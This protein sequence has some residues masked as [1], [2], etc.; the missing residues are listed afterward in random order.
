MHGWSGIDYCLLSFC[1][2]VF[3]SHCMCVFAYFRL[4]VFSYFL[5]SYLRLPRGAQLVWNWLL[6]PAGTF[7]ATPA[8]RAAPHPWQCPVHSNIYT[9]TNIHSNIYTYTNV[10]S[11]IHV[12]KSTFTQKY[13]RA[14]PHPWQGP[15]RKCKC[16]CLHKYIYTFTHTHI[17]GRALSVYANYTD[18][19]TFKYTC[20]QKYID[21]YTLYLPC[22]V[23][24]VLY[25]NCTLYDCITNVHQYI[26]ILF[27]NKCALYSSSA[28]DCS[29][30]IVHLHIG[31]IHLPHCTPALLP[32]VLRK[33]YRSAT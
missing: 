32:R 6:P 28:Y 33:L 4:C 21:T 5:Y 26:D 27:D 19:C 9:F 15:V 18:K 13:M 11:N 30:N 16:T 14:A 12:Y 24:Q 29:P 8:S 22:E 25:T 31:G 7:L 10:H 17:P 3:L 1:L 20:I 2:F 23:L